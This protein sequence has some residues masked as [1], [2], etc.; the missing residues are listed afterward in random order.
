VT[1]RGQ[2]PRNMEADLTGP[3][4]NNF[5]RTATPSCNTLPNARFLGFVTGDTESFQLAMQR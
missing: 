3:A 4:N 2:L 1:F 5:H